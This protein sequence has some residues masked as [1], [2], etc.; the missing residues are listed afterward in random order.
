[1][2]MRE[3]P[4]G[5]KA[6]DTFMAEQLF[7]CCMDR[8]EVQNAF[9]EMGIP[10]ENRCF[11]VSVLT[12]VNLVECARRENIGR[13]DMLHRVAAEVGRFCGKNATEDFWLLS[14]ALPSEVVVL[15]SVCADLF[16]RDRR[17][18]ERQITSTLQQIMETC[19]VSGIFWRAYTSHPTLEFER[20]SQTF[21][22][23]RELMAAAVMLG[24]T[25]QNISYEDLCAPGA[26]IYTPEYMRTVQQQEGRFWGALSRN[27]FRKAQDTL[28]EIIAFQFQP[29]HMNIQGASAMFYALLNKVRCAIDCMRLLSGPEAFE[30]FE[31]APRILYRKSLKEVAEQIDV[32][33]DTFYYDKS[34]SASPPPW[35]TKLSDYIHVNFCD[36]N[37]NIATAADHFGLNPA[38]ASR[39]YKRFF[40]HGILDEINLLRIEQAKQQM[41]ENRLLKDIAAAVG[42]DNPQRMNRAFQKYT[43][44]TPKEFM[45]QHQTLDF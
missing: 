26:E 16:H 24:L 3:H 5:R 6:H 39:I 28:H 34:N 11:Y 35:L 29:G 43:G 12:P 32:I 4:E 38:Y 37:L 9:R 21:D 31:T 44:L 33:F 45:E 2:Y 14:G 10:A 20:L 30:A 23:T 17:A 19:N 27:D 15:F 40:G 22:Q 8:E 25:N 41:L 13:Y 42:Y 36:P 1:M 18:L 7:G